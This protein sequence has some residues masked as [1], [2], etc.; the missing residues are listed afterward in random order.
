MFV[1]SLRFRSS[2]SLLSIYPS[3]KWDRTPIEC[4]FLP[5][6]EVSIGSPVLQTFFYQPRTNEHRP[7]WDQIRIP[8]SHGWVCMM[9]EGVDW[10]VASAAAPFRT[11]LGHGEKK[12]T[13]ARRQ[14]SSWYCSIVINIMQLILFKTWFHC[15]HI[16]MY[17][18]EFCGMRSFKAHR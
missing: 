9:G 11:E 18:H 10:P 17:V 13:T 4:I 8:G 2:W 15:S 5:S 7:M 1:M 14:A 6:K 16:G 3:Q 12:W